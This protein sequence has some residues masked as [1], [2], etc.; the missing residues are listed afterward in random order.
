MNF[1]A[2]AGSTPES[3]A[4]LPGYFFLAK[5]NF[6]MNGATLLSNSNM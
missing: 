3:A 2:T 4:L 1:G 5:P 6:S